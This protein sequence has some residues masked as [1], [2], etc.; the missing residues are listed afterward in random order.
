MYSWLF[1]VRQIWCIA[2]FVIF[3]D[4]LTL[5]NKS[6]TQ[7]FGTKWPYNILIVPTGSS[8][9]FLVQLTA[10]LSGDHHKTSGLILLRSTKAR[11]E[12]RFFLNV[13]VTDW[14]TTWSGFNLLFPHI[15]ELSLNLIWRYTT[16]D[17]SRLRFH[18]PLGEVI[19]CVTAQ[20]W[21]RNWLVATDWR[22]QTGEIW[23]RCWVSAFFVYSSGQSL[24]RLSFLECAARWRG[25]CPSSAALLSALILPTCAALCRG[26]GTARLCELTANPG[27]DRTGWEMLTT[28]RG[29]PPSSSIRRADV[30][31]SHIQFYSDDG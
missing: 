17:R 12:I 8:F 11:A 31:V 21:C 28:E 14:N 19:D 16:G 6:D 15:S 18:T 2:C 10:L 29:G 4:W 23:W 27:E 5:N 7:T 24:R 13:H 22:K 9:Q 20:S 30:L 1:C 25:S 26:E 3:F